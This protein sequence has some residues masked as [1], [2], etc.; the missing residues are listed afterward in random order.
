MKKVIKFLGRCFIVL[1]LAAPFLLCSC[2]KVK[3][4]TTP[5]VDKAVILECIETTVNPLM[6]SVEEVLVYH[7]QMAEEYTINEVF[8]TMSPET[9]KNIASVCLKKNGCTSKKDIVL[10]YQANR[11]IYDNLP[12]NQPSPESEKLQPD[13]Q[14][15]P[16]V[17]IKVDGMPGDVPPSS[18]VTRTEDDTVNGVPL[19]VTIKE[20]RSYEKQ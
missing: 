16:T 4:Y 12:V 6:T 8:C 5:E 20:E 19:K 13:K 9:L 11:A 14:I 7:G 10:E 3:E 1:A 15:P 2:E 17:E 18:V